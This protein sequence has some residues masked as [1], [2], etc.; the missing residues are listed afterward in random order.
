MTTPYTSTDEWAET[1]GY[2]TFAAY[3]ADGNPE[4]NLTKL[5]FFLEKATRILNN[6]QHLNT[7]NTNITNTGYLADI[8]D[9]CISITNRMMDVER[10]RGFMGGGFTFS[11]Q[12]FLYTYER[13]DI[14]Q[15]SRELNYRVVG[16]VG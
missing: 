1:R 4:P 3:T 8:K 12:D 15:I 14:L 7:G 10:N 11:P 13:N 16:A 6:R 2:A 9:Y 5:T